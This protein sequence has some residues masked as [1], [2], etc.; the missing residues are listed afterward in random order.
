MPF[1]AKPGCPGARKYLLRLGAGQQGLCGYQ[2]PRLLSP[3]Q[4]PHLGDL[5]R[6]TGSQPRGSQNPGPTGPAQGYPDTPKGTS[7]REAWGQPFWCTKCLP[8]SCCIWEEATSGFQCQGWL[9]GC[10]GPDDGTA[11][12]Q[13]RQGGKM[14]SAFVPL[15]LL[16][17]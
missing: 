8:V 5:L 17:P 6:L 4:R 9:S 16:T 13:W 10:S 7:Q 14:C 12:A 15:H 2:H 11:S 3:S 1:P